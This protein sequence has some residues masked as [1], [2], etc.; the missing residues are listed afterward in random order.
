MPEILNGKTAFFARLVWIFFRRAPRIVPFQGQVT[1][2]SKDHLCEAY[3][4]AYVSYV[5]KG[6]RLFKHID[7]RGH[8]GYT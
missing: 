6:S 8:I 2:E 4:T 1:V 7:H 5:F 3:V